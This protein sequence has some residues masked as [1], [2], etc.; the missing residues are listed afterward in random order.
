MFIHTNALNPI[1]FISLKNMEVEVVAM[2][3]SMF[4]GNPCTCVGNITSGGTESLLLAV[5]TYRDYGI[6]KNPDIS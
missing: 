3:A 2:T 6:A 1:R 5:K 4:N